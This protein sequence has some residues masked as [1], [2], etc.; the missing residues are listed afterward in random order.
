[1][2]I[3]SDIKQLKGVDLIW[4][5]TQTSKLNENMAFMNYLANCMLTRYLMLLNNH[6]RIFQLCNDTVVTSEKK[7]SISFSISY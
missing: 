3:K 2:R 1:M 4:I 6:C 5:L 7:E